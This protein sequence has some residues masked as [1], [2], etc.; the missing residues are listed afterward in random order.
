MTLSCTGD[1]VERLVKADP[2]TSREK[3]GQSRGEATGPSTGEK[4][5]PVNGEKSG[6]SSGGKSGPSSEGKTGTST[7]ENTDPPTG[8]IKTG[9]SS[10]GKTDQSSGGKID[11]SNRDRVGPLN[12]GKT[13][14]SSE[15]KTDPPRKIREPKGQG[16]KSGKKMGTL[17]STVNKKHSKTQSI[18][19][20]NSKP[21]IEQ[22]PKSHS[23]CLK[24]KSGTIVATGEVVAGDILH[25]DP[26][27]DGNFRVLIKEVLQRDATSW[28]PDIFGEH[29][30]K[31]LLLLGRSK[32]S[33]C[34]NLIIFLQCLHTYVAK[35]YCRNKH[36]VLACIHKYSFLCDTKMYIVIIDTI[37]LL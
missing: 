6:G 33:H 9:E 22:E 15:E 34:Q 4:T 1:L 36:N 29:C 5:D 17:A 10:V 28:F 12:A 25:G 32:M 31:E 35:Q 23:V 21:S 18:H 13:G 7:G 11:R 30:A 16:H 37:I 26:V 2:S 19:A 3:T 27:G 24:G 8:G 20:N 14:P